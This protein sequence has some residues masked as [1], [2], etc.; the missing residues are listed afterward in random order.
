MSDLSPRF[1]PVL[2][3]FPA[4]KPGKAP[5]AAVGEA[6]KLSSNESPYGPLPSVIEV[7]AEAGGSV[8]RYPD[9]G[10]E[11]LIGA[12]AERF[13]VPAGHVAVG[14]GSVGVLKQLIEAVSDPGSE[15]LYAWRS[16]EAYPTL[17]DLAGATSVRV[18][19]REATHDLAAMA[20]AITPRT[21]LV[22]VCNP[23]NPTGT[24][25]REQE[26]TEFIDQVPADCLVVLDEAYREYI[27]DPGVPDGIDLYRDRPNVAVLR[28]FS[29]AYGLAGLRVGFLI[30]Q[31]A[32]AEA[33]RKTMLPFT[34]SS[35]AQA[36][37]IASLSAENE[38]LERVETVVKERDRV[39]AALR[40]EG[41]TVPDTEANFVWLGLG[42][43][44]MRFAE[45]C[46]AAGIAVR[47]FAG[48][49]A[50][51]SI[52][53]SAANDAF[54]AMASAFPHRT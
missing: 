42:E 10:A 30:G 12:L 3:T 36:A 33:V 1:R 47:P 44:T 8:N 26:L 51:I 2:D 17:A 34:V 45:S 49:G 46:D 5:V 52:G 18:P 27:R 25:V 23:N 40:A 16:F 20:A 21:R 13:A 43:H 37:A 22:L 19:L 7:I 35:V 50:R 48:D 28:T 32:V 54:L 41:W 39:T 11:A 15:V 6:H 9:N 4:Y 14:C 53:T 38:L 29:K 31:E 24:V